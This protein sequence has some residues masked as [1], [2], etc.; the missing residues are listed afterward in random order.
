MNKKVSRRRFLQGTA[1]ITLS[2]PFLTKFARPAWAAP[3]PVPQRLVVV[4][5][6]MGTVSDMWRPDQVGANFNL[7]FI[8]QPLDAFK[9][10]CLFVSNCDNAVLRLNSDHVFGHPAKKESVLTGTLMRNAFDGDKANRVDRVLD[11]ALDA[12][13]GGPN[14]ESICNFVGNHLLA[15]RSYN[16]ASV[17]LAV[18]GRAENNHA[19]VNSSFFFEGPANPISLEANPA[20]AFNNLFT[21]VDPD[22]LAAQEALRQLRGR[23]ASVLDAVRS[24]FTDLR[25][26]LDAADRARLDDHADRIRTVEL[27]I[28][29]IVSCTPPIG[30]PGGGQANPGWDLFRDMSMREL[31]GYQIPLL[32]HAMACDMAPVGRLQFIDQ[33]D[34]YFGV[35]SVDTQVAAWRAAD[36]STA[37][38]GMVHGDASP[39]DGVP[40]RGDGVYA[41][42]L[43]DGYRFFVEQFAALLGELDSIEEDAD[44]TTVLDNTLVLLATDYG[45]GNGHSS[46]KLNFVLAGNTGPARSGYHFDCAP[47]ANFYTD[48]DYNSNQLLNSICRMFDLKNADGSDVI[49][50]GL[51][52]FVQGG[53]P[54]IF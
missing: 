28:D 42:Y 47:G 52:G 10:R 18:A 54:G 31:A 21:G 45:N 43:L 41:D 12:V 15:N 17:D 25:Q 32:A 11:M 9:D 1:G 38:H 30:I 39:V 34:P 53:I 3:A 6:A 7:P 36:P 29:E 37:W 51:E 2:L 40:T 48:S 27:G 19:Q 4:T 5:Y 16:T 46:N 24:S 8:T 23:R 49:E 20:T 35:D 14:N 33:H 50:F 26:G 22:D 13:E 44:G